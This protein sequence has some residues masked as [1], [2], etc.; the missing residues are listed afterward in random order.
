MIPGHCHPKFVDRPD[1]FSGLEVNL[2]AQWLYGTSGNGRRW[3][4]IPSTV[5]SILV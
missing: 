4:S 2:D 5:V 1:L 3:V